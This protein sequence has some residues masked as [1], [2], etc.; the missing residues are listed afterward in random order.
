MI[1]ICREIVVVCG[2]II[3]V[4]ITVGIVWSIFSE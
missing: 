4:L 3:V 1:E 2:T